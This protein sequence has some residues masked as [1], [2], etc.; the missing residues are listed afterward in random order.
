V[1]RRRV[2]VLDDNEGVSGIT[3]DVLEEHGFIVE[4]LHDTLRSHVD[5]MLAR[6]APEV[7]LL[8]SAGSRSYGDSWG[9][10]ARLRRAPGPPAVIMF[11]AHASDAR[12]AE[13]LKT[14]RSQRAG[15]AAIVRK[16]FDVDELVRVVR[17]AAP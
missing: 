16:P 17:A 2:L 4:F 10:A 8:D 15:F 3:R 11:T 14:A 12:E 13:Q 6:F 7:I 1:T 5:E 9:L